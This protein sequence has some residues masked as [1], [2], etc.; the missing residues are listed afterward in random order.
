[1]TQEENEKKMKEVS[2]WGRGPS[3]VVEQT[4][5]KEG[6]HPVHPMRKVPT[7][8]HTFPLLSLHTRH[9][10]PKAKRD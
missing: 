1:M 6:A 7:Q 5:R 3:E 4:R 8:L 10:S 2:S 9:P